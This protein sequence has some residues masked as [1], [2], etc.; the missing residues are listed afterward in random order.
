[1]RR[2][3]D[4][5]PPDKY[6][7]IERVPVFRTHRRLK[8][9]K[10]I[11]VDKNELAAIADEI[12]DDFERIGRAPPF[13]KGHTL[14]TGPDGADVPEVAQPDV[15]GGGAHFF[16][17]Q[18]A[19]DPDNHYLYCTW[20]IPK[21]EKEEVLK[22]YFSI[23]PE[24]YP[25]RKQLWPISLL[26]S[27]SPELE[28]PPIPLRYA[29]TGDE[30]P[31]YR[32]VLTNPFHYSNETPMNEDE[33]DK[34]KDDVKKDDKAKEPE[35]K[36]VDDAK[37]KEEKGAKE[38]KSDL[39][40][41][42][43]MLASLQPLLEIMPQL[44]ELAQ[45][46]DQGDGGL[47]EP[48]DKTDG[49]DVSPAKPDDVVE[50]KKD[51]PDPVRFDS[52]GSSTN[53]FVPTDKDKEKVKMAADKNDDLVKYKQAMESELAKYKAE[54]EKV[55]SDFNV[56]KKV[57]EDLNKK[58]RR[59]EAEKLVYELENTHN[60]VFADDKIRQE[61][62]DALSQL[63]PAVAKVYF[64]RA[65]VRYQKKLPAADKVKEVARYAAEGTPDVSRM[66]AEE[67]QERAILTL[68]ALDAGLSLEE[69]LKKNTGK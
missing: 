63:E 34:P 68:K 62:V 31:P 24:Y 27:S 20:A 16:V 7:Y 17:G 33:K 47:M 57:A 43:Q 18:E 4:R 52:M 50:D 23:S 9:G 66:S 51:A 65:K 37:K 36:A 46:V 26:K 64:E 35:K 58:N 6:D 42:K 38:D 10:W 1:M 21:D 56:T 8:N 60:I 32:L 69:F 13:A 67:V 11:E 59:A 39:A 53:G 48:A 55:K 54:L 40:E 5:F 15:C 45:L 25:S 28:M 2:I 22:T 44:M 30:E 61:E 12:N 19:Q 14:D 3:Q 41:I 29:L 49:D